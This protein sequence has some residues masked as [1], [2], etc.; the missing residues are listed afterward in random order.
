MRNPLSWTPL[1]LLYPKLLLSTESSVAML[2]LENWI[3][4]HFEWEQDE[5][6]GWKDFVSDPVKTV[7]TKK[8]DCEDFAFVVASWAYYRYHEV[9]FALCFD[10]LRPEHTVVAFGGDVYSSDGVYRDTSI[11]EYV[12]KKRFSWCVKRSVRKPIQA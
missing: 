7:R 2:D 3:E 5:W 1:W 9:T 10:G 4:H 12:S 8:G 11:D 6:G